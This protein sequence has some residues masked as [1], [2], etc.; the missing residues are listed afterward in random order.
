MAF[1]SFNSLNSY[2]KLINVLEVNVPGTEPFLFWFKLNDGDINGARLLNYGM[3]DKVGGN[4][5]KN[6]TITGTVPALT[7]KVKFYNSSLYF[8]GANTNWVTLPTFTIPTPT[9]AGQGYTI[10]L[11]VYLTVSAPN[12]LWQWGQGTNFS[13]ITN[14]FTNANASVTVNGESYTIPSKPSLNSWEMVTLTVEYNTAVYGGSTLRAYLNG[15]QNYVNTSAR[16][17]PNVS[18]NSGVFNGTNYIGRRIAGDFMNGYIN[19]FMFADVVLTPTQI[20]SL[21]SS[22]TYTS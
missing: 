3:G 16:Y 17:M 6:A 20:A 14:A 4:T 9:V 10:T 18:T 5:T 22:G 15:A 13:Y 7:D 8:S 1:S 21:Y 11:W 2:V 19:N 12:C